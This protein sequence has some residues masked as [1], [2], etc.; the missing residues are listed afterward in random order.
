MR[1][2]RLICQMRIEMNESPGNR[3]AVGMAKAVPRICCIE[4]GTRGCQFAKWQKSTSTVRSSLSGGPAGW[5]V[6]TR[7]FSYGNGFLCRI[8][9]SL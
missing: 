5:H 7:A 1:D 8:F 3:M 2:C 4:T 9:Q 6:F